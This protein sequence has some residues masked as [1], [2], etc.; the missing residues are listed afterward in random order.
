MK[1]FN[2]LIMIS[3]LCGIILTSCNDKDDSNSEDSKPKALEL[4]LSDNNVSVMEM[5][6]VTVDVLS[7]SKKYKAESKDP[8]KA[9]AEVS[10][11]VVSIKGVKQGETNITVTDLQTKQTQL[12]NVKILPIPD[13]VVSAYKVE[14]FIDSI[15]ELTIKSGSGSY[16]VESQDDEVLTVELKD[17]KIILKGNKIGQTKILVT[18]LQTEQTKEISVVVKENIETVLVKAGTFVM[19]SPKGEEG[20]NPEEIQRNITLTKDFYI[21]KY[22]VTN[23]QYANFL[24]DKAQGLEQVKE[25]LN[26]A[27]ADCQIKKQGDTYKADEGKE[28]YPV[29]FVS[30]AG[31]KEYVD[32]AGGRLPTE[33]EWEYAARGGSETQKFIYSGSNILADVAWYGDNSDSYIHKVGT[34]QP[35]ELG[36]YDMSG[37]V[38]EWCEDWYA[39]YEEGDQ[40]DPI[41][42]EELTYRV[43]RG[44]AWYNAPKFCRVAA[45][46]TGSP[47]TQGKH[48]GFRI[49]F[50][51]H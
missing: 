4:K 9:L 28:D 7:G 23:S 17:D 3:C 32:W 30:F 6:T 39:P 36:I 13:L 44:G 31:A 38:Y 5:Q 21:G 1:I 20:R 8:T 16:K 19:G 33:A 34:K 48:N 51:V 25:W 26:I 46:G 40:T 24:N 11:E 42:D 2:K 22:E 35:N 47:K 10:G 50:D 45:R 27:E 49:V 15:A 29:M 14:V 43:I 37:N 18:D 12:I 41:Q